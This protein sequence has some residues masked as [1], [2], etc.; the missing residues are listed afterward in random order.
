MAHLLKEAKP[1]APIV[2]DEANQLCVSIL[3]SVNMAEVT[4]T[5]AKKGPKSPEEKK[6]ADDTKAL[7]DAFICAKATQIR[8][9]V[10]GKRFLFLNHL[11]IHFAKLYGTL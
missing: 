2:T 9:I 8:R 3:A 11:D 7:K 5:L 4:F 10:A 6:Q 1:S